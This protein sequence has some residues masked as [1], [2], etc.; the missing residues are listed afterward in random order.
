VQRNVIGAL[1][2]ASA[3]GRQPWRR[4]SLTLKRDWAV[5]LGDVDTSSPVPKE[6]F[7]A[8]RG[9]SFTNPDCENDFV[10]FPIRAAAGP[11]QANIVAFHNLYTNCSGEVPKTMWAYY[12]GNGRART[13]PVLS[14]DGTEV[15]F[16]TNQGG[17][18]AWFNVLKWKKG[19]GTSPTSAVA[20]GDGSSVRSLAYAGS[21]VGNRRS[22]PF[23]D[24][25]RNVA[26]VGADNGTLYAIGPV[27]NSTQALSTMTS[28]VV[29]SGSDLT[30]PVMDPGENRIFVSSGSTLYCYE[31]SDG[32][33]PKFT[34]KGSYVVPGAGGDSVQDAALVD[35]D[36][37]RVFWF[38]RYTSVDS[39]ALV[40]ETDY[41]CGSVKDAT[42]GPRSDTYAVRAGAFDDAHYSSGGQ[43]GNLYVCGKRTNQY[44]TLYI[45]GFS[46]GVWQNISPTTNDNIA[47]AAGECSPLT[48]FKGGDNQ[49]RLFLGFSGTDQIQMWN[50]PIS[51]SSEGPDATASGYNGGSAGIIVDNRSSDA[52]ANNIYFQTVLNSAACGNYVCAVKLTQ[53]R[54]Q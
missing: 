13:S 14:R 9:A 6:H 25:W 2:S 39:S 18:T 19:Q 42:I 49:D 28:I 4:N 17:T 8:M 15:A 54:L 45:F 41:N 20:P 7:P 10:V 43:S 53:S 34:L 16:V 48:T 24:Y 50:I 35:V 12:V 47:N 3:P 1:A 11:D 5:S 36:R 44:P 23:V 21:S 29:S 40:I 46:S 26:F 27:F 52:D 33:A 38:A 22:S 30:S 31:Y 51:G 37:K 32:P